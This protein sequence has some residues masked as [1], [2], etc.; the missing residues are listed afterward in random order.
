MLQIS[1]QE[2]AGRRRRAKVFT[3]PPS[4]LYAIWQAFGADAPIVK[5]ARK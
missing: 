1:P 2:D 4:F 5:I 3:G